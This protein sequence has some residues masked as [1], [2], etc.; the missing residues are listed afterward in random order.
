[1]IYITSDPHYGHKN[2]VYGTSKWEDREHSCQPFDTVEEYNEALIADI[3]SKVG[4]DDILYI[5]GDV[6]FGG[7]QNVK[8][9]I[10]KIICRNIVL[11]YGN[12]DHNIKKLKELQQLFTATYDY[13]EISNPLDEEARIILS[14][15]PMESWNGKEK[16][17]IHLHGHTHGKSLVV[18]NRKDVYWTVTNGVYRLIDLL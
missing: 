2:Y 14:H 13:L 4:K 1:M 18:P 7:V 16:G 10:D 3:N 9:F 15:Y 11:I 12:H 5:L 6:S 8:I 17:W